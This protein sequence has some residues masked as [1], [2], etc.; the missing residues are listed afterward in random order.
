MPRLQA[1]SLSEIPA[2]KNKI[3]KR[4]LSLEKFFQN[5][6][7]NY[8]EDELSKLNEKRKNEIIELDD[9]NKKLKEKL[10]KTIEELN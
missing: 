3:I 5:K 9:S 7:I 6:Y 1:L 4:K 10:T 2:V 8:T